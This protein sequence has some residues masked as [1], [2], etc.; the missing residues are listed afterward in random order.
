MRL[1][2]GIVDAAVLQP[3]RSACGT[4]DLVSG[5]RVEWGTGQGASVAEMGGFG[6]DPEQR[7][8]M[9]LEATAGHL[10]V[11]SLSRC[12]PA[13]W[14]VTHTRARSDSYRMRFMSTLAAAVRRP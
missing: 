12:T 3:S 10:Q 7:P 13:R 5:D 6:I 8:A 14:A 1:G 2:H 9:W 11:A 4:L